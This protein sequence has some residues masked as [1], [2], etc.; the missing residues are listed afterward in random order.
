MFNKL[1]E[2]FQ[3]SIILFFSAFFASFIIS[4][5]FHYVI[6]V[7]VDKIEDRDSKN[8]AIIFVTLFELFITAFAYLLIDKM[9]RSLTPWND[10]IKIYKNNH[11]SISKR[12]LGELT[13]TDYGIHIILIVMLLEMNSSLK[14]NLHGVQDMILIKNH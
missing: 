12:N 11:L 13:V 5:F 2:L 10:L 3:L 9:I 1:F 4:N 14:H 7:H 8:I 6:D